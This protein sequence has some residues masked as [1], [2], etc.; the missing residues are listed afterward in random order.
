M[1]RAATRKAYGKSGIITVESIPKPTIKAN[2][3]LVQ[4]YNSSLNSWDLD[5]LHGSMWVIKLGKFLPILGADISG[6]VIQI[7]PKVTTLK[8]GDEVFGDIS[9]MNF[10]GLAEYIAVDENLLAIKSSKI[11]FEQAASLPQAGVLALQGIKMKNDLKS[12]DKV[13]I[14]GAGGG[15][16]TIALQILKH[17]GVEITCV[18]RPDKFEFL[19]ELGATHCIDFQTIDYTTQG[20]CY[21]LILDLFAFN[22]LN[23]YSKCLT[24][25]GSFVLI[26]GKVSNALQLM[27]LSA[28]KNPKLKVVVHQPK[29][30][31]L[32]E[33][34]EMM[35]Q[36]KI[37]PLIEKTFKLDDINDAFAYYESGEFKGK[38]AITIFTP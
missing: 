8:V 27:V 4:I 37:V 34:Q 2:Q 14:N 32:Q 17:I 23:S 7:G 21:D 30:E 35:E 11:T 36:G 38:I 33:L 16:G 3:V 6:K 1:M 20:V 13:L 12:N 24:E 28:F 19:K 18:D 31:D 5:H 22:P 29:K 26:G 15:V 10:G 25:N 9:G